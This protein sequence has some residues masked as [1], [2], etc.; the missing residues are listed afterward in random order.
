MSSLARD[1][2]PTKR[3]RLS[4]CGLVGVLLVLASL[5]GWI[6]WSTSANPADA[7]V[8]LGSLR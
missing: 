6:A 2:S 3:F 5:V 4:M 8:H 7:S 1:R